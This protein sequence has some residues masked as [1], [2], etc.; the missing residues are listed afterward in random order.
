MANI[1]YAEF[2]K[3]A[4]KK[5]NLLKEEK[6]ATFK[7][8]LNNN[9]ICLSEDISDEAF[10]NVAKRNSFDMKDLT[11]LKDAT[12]DETDYEYFI[13]DAQ[14]CI[15]LTKDA[16]LIFIDFFYPV[17]LKSGFKIN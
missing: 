7:A 5:L 1:N 4:N 9:F 17:K 2:R 16:K 8:Y 13:H 10:Y 3:Y 14:Q 6:S 11:F 12:Y 15:G